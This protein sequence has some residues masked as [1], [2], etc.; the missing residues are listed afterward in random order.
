[1][2]PDP[3]RHGRAHGHG[4]PACLCGKAGVRNGAHDA[5]HCPDTHIWL[6]AKCNDPACGYCHGRPFLAP[7][8][9]A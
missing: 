9:R 4:I 6:E 2:S 5:Y 3:V 8:P 1:M 7:V